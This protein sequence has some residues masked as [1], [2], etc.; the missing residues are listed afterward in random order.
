MTVGDTN[1][2][3]IVSIHSDELLKFRL[4]D[5]STTA[6]WTPIARDGADLSDVLRKPEVAQI[7]MG[8][9]QTADFLFV[10]QHVGPLSLEVWISPIGQRVVQPIIIDGR[11]PMKADSHG[12]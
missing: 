6:R 8:P 5:D 2:L 7:E 4:S 10:P 9:G 3:R 12:N 11:K 1:R